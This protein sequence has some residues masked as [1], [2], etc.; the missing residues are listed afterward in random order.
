MAQ[1]TVLLGGEE[2]DG[3]LAANFNGLVPD[4]RTAGAPVHASGQLA[5]ATLGD[6]TAFHVAGN[7][8]VLRRSE[9][10]ARR[11][12]SDLLKVCIQR[13]GSATIQQGDREATLTPGSMAIYDIDRPYAIRL[14]GAWRCSVIAFPRASL[15]ASR[16]FLDA[17]L[18]RPT[19]VTDGPGS[20]LGPLVA[21]A[22][23]GTASGTAAADALM[24][25]ASL[26]LLQAAL[27]SRN[28][29]SRPD[30]VRL[31]VD[32]YIRRHL[33]DPAL[34]HTA[35]AAVFHMSERTLHRLF[36]GSDQSVTGL[37]RSYRL[38][39]IRTELGSPQSAADSISQ[40]TARWG[41]HD[42]PHFVR[43]FRA[44]YGMTPSEARRGSPS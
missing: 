35:V 44:R 40:I 3:A 41:L 30:A 28:L 9:A 19:H 1:A 8:Q 33:A 10:L 26:D 42:M 17:V 43:T 39:G 32:A 12:P 29:P 36:D 18:C 27:A 7:T 2:W 4:H 37:I 23:S 16:Q 34:S 31:Q 15:V 20:V 25:Q 11:R 24:G 14:D 6:V 13:A 38:A 21:S 5:A 22:I